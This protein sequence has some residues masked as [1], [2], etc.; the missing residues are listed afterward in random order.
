MY[1]HI[2]MVVLGAPTAVVSVVGIFIG[3]RNTDMS[4]PGIWYRIP[5]PPFPWQY[6]FQYPLQVGQSWR[7]QRVRI[8]RKTWRLRIQSKKKPYGHVFVPIMTGNSK[9]HRTKSAKQ[10][11]TTETNT[12]KVKKV[13]KKE[14]KTK[15]NKPSKAT[16]VVQRQTRSRTRET[17]NAN[18]E[19]SL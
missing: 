12:K 15:V 2:I 4:W 17:T 3:R 18:K 5:Y 8:D 11:E 19:T 16:D 1:G 6:C 9:R 10:I 13:S 14:T 7:W